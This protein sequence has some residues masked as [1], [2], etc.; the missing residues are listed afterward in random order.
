MSE[1]GRARGRGRS[2]PAA[3]AE[4][5]TN[6][7]SGAAASAATLPTPEVKSTNQFSFKIFFTTSHFRQR[8]YLQRLEL[9]TLA[10]HHRQNGQQTNRHRLLSNHRFV[11]LGPVER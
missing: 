7:P 8:Q 4:G 11:E 1:R 10:I 9:L 2:R 3:P 5:S 6:E